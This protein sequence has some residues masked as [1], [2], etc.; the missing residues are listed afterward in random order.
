M[1]GNP[2]NSGLELLTIAPQYQVHEGL[3]LRVVCLSD[4]MPHSWRVVLAMGMSE[5][6][7][8]QPQHR[9]YHWC[10]RSKTDAERPGNTSKCNILDSFSSLYWFNDNKVYAAAPLRYAPHKLIIVIR[11]YPEA[12]YMERSFR[13]MDRKLW[14]GIAPYL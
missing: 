14:S 3:V 1:L 13:S 12:V 7:H 4:G 10:T 5:L 2:L 8:C 9:L 11:L 6:Y